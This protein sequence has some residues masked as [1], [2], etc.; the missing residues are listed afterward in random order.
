MV[1]G[2]RRRTPFT[3]PPNEITDKIRTSARALPWPLAPPISAARHSAVFVSAASGG[4][5]MNV[6]SAGDPFGE[7]VGDLLEPGIT[8]A[9]QDTTL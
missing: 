7:R 6:L 9:L 8:M 4:G 1:S 2:C 5:P 3:L